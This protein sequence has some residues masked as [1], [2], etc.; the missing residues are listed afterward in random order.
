MMKPL[1]SP[2]QNKPILFS[3]SLQLRHVVNARECIS[4][5][6]IFTTGMFKKGAPTQEG[7]DAL[8]ACS[9]QWEEKVG[10]LLQ[11]CNHCCFRKIQLQ[12]QVLH[13]WLQLAAWVEG[14]KAWAG[15]SDVMKRTG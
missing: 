13:R 8:H 5:E 9:G 4:K 6:G 3:P 12:P 2:E 15:Q 10:C 11:H 14:Q 7:N 1:L